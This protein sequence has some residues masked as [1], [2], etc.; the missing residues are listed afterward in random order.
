MFFKN[1]GTNSS[2]IEIVDSDA[3]LGCIKQSSFANNVIIYLPLQLS[4]GDLK[5]LNNYDRSCLKELYYS[6]DEED[7]VFQKAIEKLRKHVL[8]ADKIRVWSSHKCANEFLLLLY[9]CYLFPNKKISV[10][11][12]DEYN[13]YCWS[14]GCMNFREVN[15]LSKKEHV[16]TMEEKENYINEW[17]RIAK[18]NS[19]IRYIENGSIRSVPIDYF[20]EKI[21]SFLGNRKIKF[22]TLVGELM[23]N[24]IIDNSSSAVYSYLINRLIEQRK[25]E[26][27]RIDEN[28]KKIIRATTN[29]I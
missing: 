10:V 21:L 16:L 12:A 17:K 2:I 26:V 4:F 1:I 15:E 11:F 9:I 23:G 22:L 13:P 18:E 20:D 25:I 14:I 8:K 3:S 28:G 6:Y 7:F 5:S 24:E 29:I 19:P 27:V